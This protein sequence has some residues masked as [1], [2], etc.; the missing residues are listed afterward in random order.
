MI[1]YLTKQKHMN[2]ETKANKAIKM[3]QSYDKLYNLSLAYSGGKDSDVCLK[4]CKMAHIN[5]SV[6]HNVTTIDPPG[7]IK[8]CMENGAIIVRPEL[9]FFQLIEKKGLPAMQRRFCCQYLKEKYIADHLILGVRASESV[10]RAERYK[11]PTACRVYSKKK[12]TE[13]IL[14]I[15]NFT[16]ADIFH[17]IEDNNIKLAPHYYDNGKLCTDR[18]LGCIGCPLKGDRGKADFLMYPRFLR[19]W[20][21]AYSKY[22]ETHKA[23][24]GVYEDMVYHIFYSNHGEV[25]YQQNFHGIFPAPD[26]K[27]ILERFFNIEL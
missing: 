12:S 22:V 9:S 8:H 25:K 1:N 26:A 4:L 27:E 19:L 23:V 18:R 13:Q 15:V 2:F 6:V 11:E 24:E 20:V 5:V 21:K 17:F 14:P 7:T 16:D 3:L 10:K